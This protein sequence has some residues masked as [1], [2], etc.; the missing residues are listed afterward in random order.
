MGVDLK[1]C[2]FCGSPAFVAG[3]VDLDSYI[4]TIK[5]PECLAEVAHLDMAEAVA[6]WNARVE[7]PEL[8]ADVAELRAQLDQARAERNAFAMAARP[9]RYRDA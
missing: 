2:P 7:P 3:D 6:K 8:R 4:C 9:V 5:C 1:P